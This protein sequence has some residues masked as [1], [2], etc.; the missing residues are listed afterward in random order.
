MIGSQ[1]NANS[2]GV[3]SSRLRVPVTSLAAE[4]CK[5]IE[6]SASERQE[7]RIEKNQMEGRGWLTRFGGAG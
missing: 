3:M 7:D 6:V 4:F 5:Q 2:T 1:C